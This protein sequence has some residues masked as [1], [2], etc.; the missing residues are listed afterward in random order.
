MLM[1]LLSMHKRFL[2]GPPGIAPMVLGP[3]AVKRAQTLPQPCIYFDLADLLKKQERG[4]TPFTPAVTTLLQIHERMSQIVASGGAASA[5]A[6]CAVLAEDFR[7]RIVESGLPF[8]MRLVSPS[9]AVTY[10]DC[11][12]VSAKALFTLLKDEYGIWLCPNGGAKADS[13]FR[14]GHIVNHPLSDNALLVSTLKEAVSSLS[15]K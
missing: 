3:R 5:V 2:P 8:E 13:S 1:S 10:I 4:Q 6:S 11:P 7:R 12:D 15:A 14:V 9:N